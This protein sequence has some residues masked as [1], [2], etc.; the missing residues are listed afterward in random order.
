MVNT[1]GYHL[2][3]NKQPFQQ[4]KCKG[5]NSA[6]FHRL[7]E[8]LNREAGPGKGYFQPVNIRFAAVLFIRKKAY[9]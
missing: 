7:H 6:I 5:Y 9:K 8:W 3:G 1:K 4:D 2:R